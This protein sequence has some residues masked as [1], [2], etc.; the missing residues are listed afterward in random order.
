MSLCVLLLNVSR[1]RF[2]QSSGVTR[3]FAPTGLTRNGKPKQKVAVLSRPDQNPASGEGW[4]E[5]AA[6]EH[7]IVKVPDGGSA[8]GLIKED[9]VRV[10]VAVEIVNQHWRPADWQRRTRHA[11][12]ELNAV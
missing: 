12:Q 6:Y 1:Y 2:P 10:A 4:T 8:S 7:I 5:N 9:N 11:T 3:T